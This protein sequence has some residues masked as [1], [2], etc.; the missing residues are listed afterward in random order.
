MP[1]VKISVGDV[2]CLRQADNYGKD[3]VYWLANLRHGRA[4]DPAHTNLARLIFDTDY[5]T[6]LPQMLSIGAG[7]TTRFTKDVVYDK[8]CPSGSY[9]Y[10]VIHFMERDTPLANYFGK[11][12]QTISVI[13]IGLAIGALI[14]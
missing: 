5:D 4:V 10:G 11:I 14:G 2:A 3:D 1:R 9:V 7:E 8:D 12:A 6:S 13:L